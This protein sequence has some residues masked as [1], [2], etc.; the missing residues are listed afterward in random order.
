M[1][2][3]RDKKHITIYLWQKYVGIIHTSTNSNHEKWHAFD[4]ACFLRVPIV[5]KP[6]LFKGQQV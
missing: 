3:N 4:E 6:V 1:H 5:F 2:K